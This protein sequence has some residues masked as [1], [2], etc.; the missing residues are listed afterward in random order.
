MSKNISMVKSMQGFIIAKTFGTLPGAWGSYMEK[1]HSS[2]EQGELLNI[3]DLGRRYL[4][5]GR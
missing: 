3:L 2:G 1:G 4:I 5:L